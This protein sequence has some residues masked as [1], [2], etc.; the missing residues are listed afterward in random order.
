MPLA[1]DLLDGLRPGARRRHRRGPGGPPGGG[2]RGRRS[3]SASTPP[4]TR[5][6]RRARRGGGPHYARSGADA[7]PV[8]RRRVRRRGGLPGVRAHRGGR[9]GH[10]RGGPGP[11]PRRPLRLLP[12]P[13]AAP[14]ARAAAGSTT[15]RSTRPSSTGASARTWWRTTSIE[16]VEKDVFIPFIHR[17][18]SRYVNAMA[19]AGLTLRRMLE[20][21]PPAGFLARAAEYP[22]PPHHPPPARAGGR[23]RGR[24]SRDDGPAVRRPGPGPGPSWSDEPEPAAGR[25]ADVAVAPLARRLRPLRRGRRPARLPALPGAVPAGPGGRH[26]HQ[27]R[28]VVA[29][30]PRRLGALAVP[31]ARRDRVRA[32]QPRAASGTRRSARW[33]CR[34]AAPWPPA[35]GY[36]RYLDHDHRPAG[37]ERGRR[38]TPRPAWPAPSS[39]GFGSERTVRREPAHPARA[40][41]RSCLAPTS[42]EVTDGELSVFIVCVLVTTIGLAG[43]IARHLQHPEVARATTSSPAGTSCSTAAWRRW[44]CSSASARSAAARATSASVATGSIGFAAAVGRRRAR[45]RLARGVRHRGGGR[46]AGEPAAPGGVRRA[47]LPADRAAG[48]AVEAPGPAPRAW[49][50]SLAAMVSVVSTVLVTSLFTGFLSP[51]VGRA[52]A[53][54]RLRRA[55][56]G[57]V[58]S[59]TTTR[60][61]PGH[62]RVDRG[63]AGGRVRVVLVRF[64]LVPGCCSLGFVLLGLP[65]LFVRVRPRRTVDLPADRRLRRRRR[66]RPRSASLLL[67]RPTLGRVGR[68]SRARP[69]GR[70]SGPPPSPCSA[71]RPARLDEALWG[72]TVTLSALV[73]RGGRGA[74]RPA[75]AHRPMPVVDR[76]RSARARPDRRLRPGRGRS[77]VHSAG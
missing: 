15:R 40:W 71:R 25:H 6:S 43:D 48:G 22:R 76:T 27:H 10:R 24:L 73:G 55:A 34:P 65:P 30:P 70:R 36:V 75:R 49:S 64:R 52:V 11:A 23:A 21:A 35:L 5:W 2:A 16:E 69:W 7:L 18:M 38:R 59:R 77:L 9:R 68:R 58:A 63:P 60:A 56:G 8:R 26:R 1:A 28:V 61:G 19:D 20:P 72:G 33:C 4:P 41:R 42:P 51:L 17:P 50:A 54:G 12:E 53:A 39:A 37:L 45:R 62:R 47:G 29:A 46:G 66:G 14:D 74:G 57:G 67:G 13:P 31:A 3:W 32:R 44:G